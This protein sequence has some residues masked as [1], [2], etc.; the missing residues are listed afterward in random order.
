[1]PVKRFED[2]EITLAGRRRVLAPNELVVQTFQDQKRSRAGFGDILF[3]P[4][5][6]T[7]LGPAE[8]AA[9]APLLAVLDPVL[10][11]RS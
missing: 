3:V 4:A 2:T 1:M 9:L 5:T 8:R 10:G 6:A 11:E 7:E